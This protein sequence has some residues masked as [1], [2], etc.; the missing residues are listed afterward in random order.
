MK[1]VLE[2]PELSYGSSTTAVN[3]ILRLAGTFRWFPMASEGVERI[4]SRVVKVLSMFGVDATEK[5]MNVVTADVIEA[6]RPYRTAN[7]P[8]LGDDDPVY[9]RGVWRSKIS[10]VLAPAA[11]SAA[12]EE[13]R[14]LFKPP[15]FPFA[16]DASVCGM[17]LVSDRD[18]LV[19]CAEDVSCRETLWH[20]MCDVESDFWSAITAEIAGD[21]QV[22]AAFG[23]LVALYAEG[24]YPI[25][26]IGGRF[27]TFV[28]E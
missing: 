11:S 21:R 27:V 20:L 10:D 19:R 15:L 5:E 22:S 25:G 3:R 13:T 26:F 17:M 4:A 12:S 2:I 14:K 7:A 1:T 9:A 28:H 16:G 6:S 23:E 24:Y 8:Q 18:E